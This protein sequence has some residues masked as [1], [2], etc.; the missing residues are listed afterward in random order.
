MDTRIGNRRASSSPAKRP[1][2]RPAWKSRELMPAKDFKFRPR[3]PETR[4]PSQ[5][6]CTEPCR[7]RFAGTR[8][9]R[10][11]RASCWYLRICR[12]G[13]MWFTSRL[14]ISHTMSAR[15]RWRLRSGRPVLIASAALV[16]GA[17]L[18][19]AELE[20][21]LQHTPSGPASAALFRSVA[22]PGG[23]VSVRKPPAESRPALTSLISAAPR[24]AMLY[25]LRAHEAE[26]AVDFAAAEA[27]WKNYAQNSVD[28]YAAQIE[29]ADFYHR[30]IRTKD[31]LAALKAATI[32]KDD[33]LQPAAA[34][35]AWSAFGRMAALVQQETGAEP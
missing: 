34:Q 13:N 14:K 7:W 25:R 26:L 5:R 6:R 27:D 35:K 17:C 31:E 2:S 30:R 4:A 28:Q 9:R 21:W 32:V 19:H 24:H 33:P 12:P 20:P 8:R 22:M 3:F 10:R 23:A 11:I 1:C 18:V 16:G 15:G 29:L